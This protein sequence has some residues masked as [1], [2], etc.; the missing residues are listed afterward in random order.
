MGKKVDENVD[1]TTSKNS[2]QVLDETNEKTQTVDYKTYDRAMNTIGKKN[3]ELQ[4]VKD[5][6]ATYEKAEV[7][8][9]ERK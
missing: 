5:K 8:A 9:E 4:S 2:D 3:E 1:D 7:E 6:L